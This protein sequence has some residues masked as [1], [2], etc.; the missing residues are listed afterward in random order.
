ML[1]L[2]Q[3]THPTPLHNEPAGIRAGDRVRIQR[4]ENRYPS[5]GTWPQFRGRT[6]VVVQINPD[7]NRPHLTEYGVI[8]RAVPRDRAA[9]QQRWWNG[10]DV[11]W[12]KRHEMHPLASVRPVD[13]RNGRNGAPVAARR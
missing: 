1:N 13:G 4:D 10:C 8:F 11:V 12:F 9:S 7:H 3:P 6:G 5:G 2:A